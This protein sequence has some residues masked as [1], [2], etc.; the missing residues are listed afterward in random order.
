MF[1]NTF[2][3]FRTTILKEEFTQSKV[4][5]AIYYFTGMRKS[6]QFFLMPSDYSY[7]NAVIRAG[8]TS[9]VIYLEASYTI[10]GAYL[11]LEAYL[12]GEGIR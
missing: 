4:P 12:H 1:N 6:G 8:R 10:A 9:H 3:S 5:K 7:D 2:N 11:I